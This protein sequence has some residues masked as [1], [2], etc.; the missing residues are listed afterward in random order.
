MVGKVQLAKQSTGN[1]KHIKE[2][3]FNCIHCVTVNIR[4]AVGENKF[5]AVLEATVV[6]HIN[7]DVVPLSVC[8]CVLVTT[9]QSVGRVTSWCSDSIS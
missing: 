7:K 9:C 6:Q 3:C 2:T 8:V 4:V 5:R 1:F